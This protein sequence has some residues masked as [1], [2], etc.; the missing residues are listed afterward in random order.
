[1]LALLGC[2]FAHLSYSLRTARLASSFFMLDIC[3]LPDER[4]AKIWS[5][6]QVRRRRQSATSI[7]G[8]GSF[9]IKARAH[10]FSGLEE[11]K[12]SLCD[13]HFSAGL[14]IA[15]RARSTTLG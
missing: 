3:P 15:P 1:M 4:L 10:F 7:N 5:G 11:R 13:L 8:S 9:P 14:G 6:G 12:D 2:F